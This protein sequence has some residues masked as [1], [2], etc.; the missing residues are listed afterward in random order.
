MPV[1]CQEYYTTEQV[2]GSAR[3]FATQEPLGVC[4]RW[5]RVVLYCLIWIRTVTWYAD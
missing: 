3:A 2:K 4:G 1:L 5:Q